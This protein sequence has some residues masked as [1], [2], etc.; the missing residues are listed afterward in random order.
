MKLASTINN[1]IIYMEKNYNKKYRDFIFLAIYGMKYDKAVQ[2][3]LFDDDED[4]NLANS[5]DNTEDSKV[6]DT[7]NKVKSTDNTGGQEVKT[8]EGQ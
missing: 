1:Y 6:L 4:D 8:E 7:A 3:G 5:M 2:L